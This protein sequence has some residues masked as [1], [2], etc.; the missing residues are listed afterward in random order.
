MKWAF[1]RDESEP[2]QLPCIPLDQV[3]EW[4]T[5]LREY[6]LAHP[7]GEHEAGGYSTRPAFLD[8]LIVTDTNGTR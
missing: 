2:K 1:W 3:L 8:M 7:Y 6:D 4:G 5:R